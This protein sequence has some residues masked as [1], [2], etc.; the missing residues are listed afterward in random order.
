MKLGRPKISANMAMSADGKIAA[1]HGPGGRFTSQADRHHM[2][3]LRHD[4]DAVLIGARTLRHANPCLQV[5]EPQAVRA[6]LASGRNHQPLAVIV[7]A[8]GDVPSEGRVMGQANKEASS[9]HPNLQ[10]PPTPLVVTGHDSAPM[11]QERLGPRA[12]VLALEEGPSWASSLVEA[13]RLRGIEHLL[14]EGGGETLWHFAQAGLLDVLHVTL[15]PCVLGGRQAPTL[16][17]GVGFDLFHRLRLQLQTATV[18]G[19]EVYVTYRV[20]DFAGVP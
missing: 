11:L 14:V 1:A 16:V 7:T 5:K 3:R 10:P 2:D 20:A 19:D 12:A 6:R 18:V 8:S 13:L 17:G 15:A 9:A 4:V